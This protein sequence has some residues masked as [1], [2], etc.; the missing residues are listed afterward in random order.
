MGAQRGNFAVNSLSRALFCYLWC[1]SAG[2]SA[3]ERTG[4][5][6]PSTG[7]WRCL[8]DEHGCT[9]NNPPPLPLRALALHSAYWSQLDLELEGVSGE[10]GQLTPPVKAE[11][12]IKTNVCVKDLACPV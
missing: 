1:V 3:C 10:R 8:G 5:S 2:S 6:A 12:A 9:K 7:P 4:V 11:E